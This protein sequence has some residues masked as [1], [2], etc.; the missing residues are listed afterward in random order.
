MRDV[1][2]SPAT[3]VIVLGVILVGGVF[4]WLT[5]APGPP[6]ASR[7]VLTQ[8]ARAYLPN[9]ALSEVHMQ[10]AESMVD[11]RVIEILG[12]ITN[13]GNR[14]IKSALVTCVFRDYS[15][16]EIGR[17]PAWVVSADTNGLGSGQTRDFRLAFDTIPSTWNQD[18]P[19][20][21]ISQIQFE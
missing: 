4:A 1:K 20:L 16:R 9:L 12:K 6:A 11:L 5:F 17:E 3:I 10:A 15:N 18:M 19:T 21:V 13:N 14:R 2:I 7:P 8:E